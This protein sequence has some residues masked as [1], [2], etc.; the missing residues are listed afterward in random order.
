M[1]K[2]GRPPHPDIL[3]PREWH[4]LDLLRRAL[5]NEQIAQRLDISFATA[6]YHVAEIISK[7]GVQTREQAAW[8]PPP[9]ERT[10]WERALG[11][12]AGPR[13]PF[14][15][16]TIAKAVGLGVATAILAGVLLLGWAAFGNDESTGE[17]GTG[18]AVHLPKSRALLTIDQVLVHAGRGAQ[19]PVEEAQVTLTTYKG[20]I[21][22]ISDHGY[23]SVAGLEA[24]KVPRDSQTWLVFL[25]THQRGVS[26]SSDSPSPVTAAP[27]ECQQTIVVLPDALSIPKPRFIVQ[28][29]DRPCPPNAIRPRD[30]S[31]LAAASLGYLSGVLRDTTVDDIR[32]D[33]MD[34]I[35]AVAAIRAAG[36][37]I[38]LP[39]SDAYQSIEELER[40]SIQPVWLIRLKGLLY[41]YSRLPT[42]AAS[43][44]APTC[45]EFWVIV[46]SVGVALSSALTQASDCS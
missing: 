30:R 23:E 40:D 19:T 25:S 1:G 38:S 7:L 27:D 36:G 42:A 34:V 20:A 9:P 43:T 24:G 37:A 26:T 46:N 39:A 29:R 6:K 44:P 22:E 16:L 45:G 8:Q 3:T 14:G 35:G 15:P 12:L 31:V 5:T 11:P 13:R 17:R 28:G 32:A 18:D 41:D 2:R 10:W 21:D 4:V 33:E